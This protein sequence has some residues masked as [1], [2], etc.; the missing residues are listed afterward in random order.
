[1]KNSA[2]LFQKVSTGMGRA[3]KEAMN[4]EIA[5]MPSPVGGATVGNQKLQAF[6]ENV[7][8]MATRSVKWPGQDQ[9]SDVK[10]RIEQ[11]AVQQYNQRQQQAAPAQ[12]AAPVFRSPVSVGGGGGTP[13]PGP[14]NPVSV[15]RTPAPEPSLGRF[16]SLPMGRGRAMDD[17]TAQRFLEAVGGIPRRPRA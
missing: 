17:A 7:D 9:A 3:S 11:Q 16:G 6:Q 15:G 8:Q 4:I 10:A 5:N 14:A 1:M 13:L 2:L 12:P